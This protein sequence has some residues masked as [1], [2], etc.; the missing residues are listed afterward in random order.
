MTKDNSC[1]A[2]HVWDGVGRCHTCGT[3][4]HFSASGQLR[5]VEVSGT[6][7]DEV[8]RVAKE[9]A[10]HVGTRN[11]PK[12]TQG[13]EESVMIDPVSTMTAIGSGLSL[14]D[15]F[16]DL[17]R[18]LRSGEQRSHRVEAKQESGALVIR[19]DGNVVE[20]VT[21]QQL[22]LGEWDAARF[23]ALRTRVS[24][25]WNQFNGL[26]AQIPNLSVDEQVRIKQR[27][28]SMRQDLCKD[29]REMI[30]ISEKVLGVPLGDHY[31][32]YSTCQDGIV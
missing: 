1:A 20:Q 24:S 6:S 25:L 18:K 31:T 13:L 19:R 10:D 7:P 27:M 29:F 17:V 23:D 22:R 14:V 2:G 4:L 12:R 5:A 32:L 9:L 21:S 11:R 26:Y 16:V 30:D 15:K 3:L 28:E 8:T